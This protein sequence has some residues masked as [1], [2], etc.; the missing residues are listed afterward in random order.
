MGTVPTVVEPGHGHRG[1]QTRARRVPLSLPR[2]LGHSPR[3]AARGTQPVSLSRARILPALSPSSPGRSRHLPVPQGHQGHF[4]ATLLPPPSRNSLDLP[5]TT[6]RGHTTG[7]L[8][9]LRPPAPACWNPQQV[10]SPP[11]GGPPS[12]ASPCGRPLPS[13]VLRPPQGPSQKPP[14]AASPP[15]PQPLPSPLPLQLPLLDTRTLALSFS[16]ALHLPGCCALRSR[17]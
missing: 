11:S 14:L 17:P 12:T 9:P 5:L 4:T 15:A 16:S 1:P 7:P 6:A 13:P 3:G 10:I 2:C 8:P